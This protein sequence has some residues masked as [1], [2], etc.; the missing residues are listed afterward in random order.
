MIC[1]FNNSSSINSQI[2]HRI[3]NILKQLKKDDFN[4]QTLKHFVKI[5][6]ILIAHFDSENELYKDTVSLSD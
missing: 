3:P 4:G 6:K 1:G 2:I 5:L